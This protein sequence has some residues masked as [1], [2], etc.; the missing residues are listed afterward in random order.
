MD[1]A[2]QHCDLRKERWVSC[3]TNKKVKLQ[4][5]T[6]GTCERPVACGLLNVADK[7]VI[8]GCIFIFVLRSVEV[9]SLIIVNFSRAITIKS[10]NLSDNRSRTIT[11]L[12]FAVHCQRLSSD[13]TADFS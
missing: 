13:A 8:D 9:S 2:S 1:T 11:G 12:R 5:Q 3:V 7:A 10:N 4:D 6:S